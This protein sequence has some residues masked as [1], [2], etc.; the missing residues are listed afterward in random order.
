[1]FASIRWSAVRDLC[2]LNKKNIEYKTA[3]NT[4]VCSVSFFSY[5]ITCIYYIIRRDEFLFNCN[6]NGNRGNSIPQW[7]RQCGYHILLHCISFS[8][9][10]LNAE[11]L[12][13]NTFFYSNIFDFTPSALSTSLNSIW[14]KRFK[15]FYLQSKRHMLLEKNATFSRRKKQLWK[16]TFVVANKIKS[17]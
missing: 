17:L 5:L 14:V 8:I 16:S 13:S 11:T 12:Y 3:F 10:I 15:W 1:M 4:S 9:A 7:F 2:N 6:W